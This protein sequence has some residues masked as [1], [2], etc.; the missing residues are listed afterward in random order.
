LAQPPASPTAHHD[1]VTLLQVLSLRDFRLFLGGRLFGTL[2]T[3]IQSVAVGWQIYEATKSPMALGFVGLAQFLPMFLL[4]LPAGDIA[5]RVDRRLIAAASYFFQGVSVGLLGLLTW[6]GMAE[7]TVWPFYLAL[8]IFGAA[9]A[10]SG[11]ALR[12]YVPLLVSKPQLPRA[13]SISSALFQ[14]GIIVGPALGGFIYILGPLAA[15]GTCFVLFLIVAVSFIT[16]RTRHVPVP[17]EAGISSFTRVTAG[18][19][20]IRR[21]PIIMGAV[22]LDLFAVLLGGAVALLPI[23]ASDILHVGPEGLGLLRSGPAIGALVINF[24]IIA[25]PP[26]RHAGLLMFACVAIFGIAT[27]AFGLSENFMLSMGALLVMGGADMVSV[28]VRSTLIP[29]ATPA[30]KLGRVSAVDLLFISASNELGEFE[31]GVMAGLLGTVPSVVFG[32][33]GTLGVV[34]LWMWL[35]PDLRKVDRLMDVRPDDEDDPP[36][37]PA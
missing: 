7:H 33:L 31:S 9:R 26:Q 4:L 24:L 16:I 27:I 28:W 3:Q 1:Q 32:G 35:F 17:V 22:S 8:V 30:D 36:P 18:I 23:Y 6:S 12:A 15:Y 2:A 21:K 11:P 19:S 34:G 29:L 37:K 10:F 25:R 13:I 14:F 5:D 20:Y